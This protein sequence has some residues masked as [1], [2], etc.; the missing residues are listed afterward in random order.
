MLKKKI[1]FICTHNSCRS[2]IAEGLLNYY[3]GDRFFAMSAG[4]EKT[5]VH[6]LAVQVM[7][8]IDIDISTQYS[9]LIDEFQ[10][11]KFD[12][13]VTVCDH[14]NETCPFYPGKKIIHKGFED[15]SKVDGS[16]EEQLVAFRNTRDEIKE[17][18]LKNICDEQSNH[19]TKGKIHVK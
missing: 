19:Q 17:W 4:V 3:C 12:I 9:K 14:A 8:E 11:D 5:R 18:I 6:P 16:D 13:V 7:N 2:Q 1:L 15:P 10:N